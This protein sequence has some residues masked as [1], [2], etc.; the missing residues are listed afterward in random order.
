MTGGLNPFRDTVWDPYMSTCSVSGSGVS[1][2]STHPL[3]YVSYLCYRLLCQI[4]RY[5]SSNVFPENLWSP[6]IG[7]DPDLRRSLPKYL[8]HCKPRQQLLFSSNCQ[9][10][11]L[12][13]RPRFQTSPQTPLLLVKTPLPF[14][15]T[16]HDHRLLPLMY[17]TRV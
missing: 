7:T 3:L 4:H 2:M 12:P 16:P 15:P 6:P 1:R 9:S 8:F 14:P 5:L 17:P 10:I 11:L 13:V